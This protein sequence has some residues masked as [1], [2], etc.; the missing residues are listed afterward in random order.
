[1][2]Q[3]ITCINGQLAEGKVVSVCVSGFGCVR[4][5]SGWNQA[6]F[7]CRSVS[8]GRAFLLLLKGAARAGVFRETRFA[9]YVEGIGCFSD[10]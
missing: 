4:T 8:D 10:F 7:L 9:H 3:H 1:M 5:V 2:L 6:S